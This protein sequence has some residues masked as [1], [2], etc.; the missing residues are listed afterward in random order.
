MS[1]LARNADAIQA[2]AAA[3]TAVTAVLAV[4][5]VLAQMR[6][7][8]ATSRAQTARESYAAHLTL[9]VANP[10]FAD[11]A[12]AC[13]LAASPKAGAYAAYIDHLLYAAEQML[14][15]DPSWDATFAQALTPH[16]A[17]ICAGIPGDDTTGMTQML[18]DFR[19][20][21]CPGVQLCNGGQ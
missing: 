2:G 15:V 17:A 10:D 16:A 8:E 20:K 14:E 6:A 19:T 13:A 18:A 5:G 3:I 1:W 12:D 11:P 7:A 21:T 9:A 4:V